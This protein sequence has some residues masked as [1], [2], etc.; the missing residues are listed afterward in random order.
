MYDTWL[1]PSLGPPPW[2]SQSRPVPPLPA[3]FRQPLGSVGRSTPD[4]GTPPNARGFTGF[5]TAG[6]AL[7]VSAS[8]ARDS[9][10]RSPMFTRHTPR[11][12]GTSKCPT[13]SNLLKLRLPRRLDGPVPLQRTGPFSLDESF[14]GRFSGRSGR[15]RAPAERPPPRT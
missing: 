10:A 3:V 4:T 12:T 15:G 11:S 14:S 9:L 7:R 8:G 2:P 5:T 13:T 1:P 6:G